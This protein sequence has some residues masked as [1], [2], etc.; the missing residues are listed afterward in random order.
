MTEEEMEGEFLDEDNGATLYCDIC[1][2]DVRSNEAHVCP[3][4]PPEEEEPNVMKHAG[5]PLGLK[6]LPRRKRMDGAELMALKKNKLQNE[7]LG[8]QVHCEQLQSQL[9]AQ[10]THPFRL[11][12]LLKE[13]ILAFNKFGIGIWWEPSKDPRV[14]FCKN[15]VEI[16]IHYRHLLNYGMYQ[17]LRMFHPISDMEWTPCNRIEGTEVDENWDPQKAA[18]C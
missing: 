8:L 16:A 10:P 14:K 6:P 9:D 18:G 3:G 15:E 11:E 5:V 13:W 2:E 4:H 12:E 17:I 1:H 7:F